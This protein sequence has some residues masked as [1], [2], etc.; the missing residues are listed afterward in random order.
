[1]PTVCL[2]SCVDSRTKARKTT[3]S[4]K[5]YVLNVTDTAT[6]VRPININRTYLSLRN[7]S[8]GVAIRYAYSLADLTTNGFLLNFG[9]SVD[10]ESP[11][12][13]YAKSDVVGQVV[14]VCVDEGSG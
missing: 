6:V 14:P 13:I 3:T 7:L 9:E 5:T 12:A 2:A 10:L 4:A 11:D 8:A 1:M